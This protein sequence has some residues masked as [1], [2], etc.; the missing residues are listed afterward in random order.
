MK[1]QG[2]AG[3][4]CTTHRSLFKPMVLQQRAGGRIQL[5]KRGQSRRNTDNTLV[6][7]GWAKPQV[8]SAHL[9]HTLGVR[10]YTNFKTWD[11]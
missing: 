9:L 7:K 1:A 10:F 6:L 8:I 5:G 11:R 4:L 3:A 2:R